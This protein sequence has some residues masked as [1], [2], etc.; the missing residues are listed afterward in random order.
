MRPAWMTV[1]EGGLRNDA[2]S[3]SV[4]TTNDPDVSA[5]CAARDDALRTI[6]TALGAVAGIDHPSLLTMR[7]ALIQRLQETRQVLAR[8][9]ALLLVDQDLLRTSWVELQEAL[10]QIQRMQT[11]VDNFSTTHEPQVQGDRK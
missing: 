10:G 4:T 5:L 11:D 7:N 3:P 8:P 9:A 6:E 2:P 1:H